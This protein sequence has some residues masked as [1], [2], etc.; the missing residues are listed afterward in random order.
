M[1]NK[2]V[3]N[4][5][6]EVKTFLPKNMKKE[7]IEQ[8]E[9]LINQIYQQQNDKN[10]ENRKISFN[11]KNKLDT[12]GAYELNTVIIYQI[13]NKVLKKYNVK[14]NFLMF[15]EYQKQRCENRGKI[16][17]FQPKYPSAYFMDIGKDIC[18]YM[19]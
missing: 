17:E 12:F 7:K 6:E 1:N 18:T 15:S 3:N 2:N 10:L 8:I 9:F 4:Y 11:T 5:I 19:R 14:Y 13:I 16:F